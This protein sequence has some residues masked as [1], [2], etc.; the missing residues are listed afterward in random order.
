MKIRSKGREIEIAEG[1]L[2]DLELDGFKYID[3]VVSRKGI[4]LQLAEG[5]NDVRS[6]HSRISLF[7]WRCIAPEV[8]LPIFLAHDSQTSATRRT[9]LLSNLHQKAG[10]Q[11]T[12][13]AQ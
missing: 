13:D 1:K 6:Q 12:R 9:P 8:M 7:E 3:E 5:K 4:Q 10:F 11:S 2:L